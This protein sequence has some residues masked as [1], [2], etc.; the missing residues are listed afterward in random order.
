M[1]FRAKSKF[2]PIVALAWLAAFAICCSHE[3]QKRVAVP[4]GALRLGLTSEVATERFSAWALLAYALDGVSVNI[5]PDAKVSVG[6]RQFTNE[7][8][9]RVR[10][11]FLQLHKSERAEVFRYGLADSDNDVVDVV[12]AAVLIEYNRLATKPEKSD[13]LQSILP[14]VR[15]ID[16]KRSADLR[17]KLLWI[18][19][20]IAN[21]ASACGLTNSWYPTLCCL[22]ILSA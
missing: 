20:L 18:E 15:A 9:S 3:P 16:E 14:E 7:D 4:N 13:F 2:F 21:D 6:G 8:L 10:E 17:Q 5:P 12:L 19:K 22:R 11:T 1:I